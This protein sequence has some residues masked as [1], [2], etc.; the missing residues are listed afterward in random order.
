[1]TAFL[2]YRGHTFSD[3]FDLPP[4]LIYFTCALQVVCSVGVLRRPLARWAAA[5]L[6]LTTLGAIAT[7]LRIGSPQTAAAAVF[8]T[9]IQIWFGAKSHIRKTSD[10]APVDR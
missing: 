7:H 3:R 6:T 5:A 8:Y 4:W 10:H 9:V 1:M 2:E